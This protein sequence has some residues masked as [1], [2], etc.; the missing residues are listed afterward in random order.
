M[1][2]YKGFEEEVISLKD[3]NFFVGENSTGKTSIL[4]LIQILNSREFWDFRQ[5]NN[6]QVQLGYFDEIFNKNSVDGFFRIGVEF[7]G[8]QDT[9]ETRRVLFEFRENESIPEVS[10]LKYQFEKK[11]Y[12]IEFTKKQVR[13]KSKENDAHISFLE[14]AQDF[15]FD[16][17]YNIIKGADKTTPFFILFLYISNVIDREKGPLYGFWF[18]ERKLY[19][20]YFW[21]APIRAKARRIYE[22]YDVK[23]SPEGEH[24]PSLLKKLFTEANK[25]ETKRILGVLNQ[26]GKESNLYDEIM[27]KNFGVEK[28]S[29]FEIVVKYDNSEIKLP[30]VGYGVSQSLPLIVDILSSKN[31]CFSIQQPEVHLHP[32]AQAAFGTFLYNAVVKDNNTFLLETHSDF[33]I[34]RFRYCLLKEQGE[35]S[36]PES[37]VLFFERRKHTNSI[38]HLEIDDKGAFKSAVPYSYKSFFIDEELKVLEL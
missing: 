5:F 24:V 31:C 37:Q 13:C 4:K 12:L 21:L 16:K 14:W 27:V 23:Y 28:T 36:A 8:E 10:R 6:S 38:T 34:N 11:H 18:N 29:P 1:K 3:V 9:S 33:T 19:E 25:K 15:S 22:S 20:N 32:K 17:K 30:N 2:N 7:P 26:F 35:G